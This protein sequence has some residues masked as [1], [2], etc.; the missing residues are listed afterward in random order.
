MYP[1]KR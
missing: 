1:Y